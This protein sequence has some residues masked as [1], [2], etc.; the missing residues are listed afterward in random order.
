M[1]LKDPYGV[2]KGRPVDRRKATG[3]NT[4][5]QIR[6]V[7]ATTDW[8]IAVNCK[9]SQWPSEVEYVE[10]VDFRHPLLDGLEDLPQ[11]FT[12]LPSRPGGHALDFIRMNLFDRTQLV[13][14][15][16]DAPG[17][18]DDLNE[19]IDR[20]VQRAFEDEAAEVYAFGGRWGPEPTTPDKIFGFRPG[21]GI[22]EIHM[23]QGN[24]A[25]YVRD[26][27]VYQ[28]GALLIHLP[29]EG[30]W[31]GIFTKFQSQRWH[32][33]DTTGHA[34]PGPVDDGGTVT[35]DPGPD[36]PDLTVRIVGALVNPAGG[37]QEQERVTLI[38]TTPDAIDLAGWALADRLKRR[39]V[40]AGV[41]G[42]GET[43]RLDVAPPFQL[44]NAGGLITLLDPA[45]L[46]VHGVAYT[47][48]QARREGWTVVF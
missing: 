20:H 27:G 9:S 44:S 3:S 34:I 45:G 18:D 38:N 15:P 12:P 16:F 22:H 32:T 48:E 13:P 17:V 30:R 24:S 29:G 39:H 8:R 4:H 7:D 47:Q 37:G 23:N 35:P 31:V 11:G 19:K 36:E 14:L 21:N 41:L 33:D 1:P 26:D 46:K 42:A 28:D 25:Q 40:L 5:F 6:L 2:L 10:N 43:A